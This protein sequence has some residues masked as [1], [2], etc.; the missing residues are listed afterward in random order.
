M[1]F[2][3]SL[4]PV[5]V[6]SIL[7]VLFAIERVSVN[8]R[9]KND[10]AESSKSSVLYAI[11]A[12]SYILCILFSYTEFVF[13]SQQFKLANVLVGL[14][15]LIAGVLLRNAS[16]KELGDVWSFHLEPKSTRIIRSGPYSYFSHPYYLA[17][18]LELAGFSMIFNSSVAAVMIIT[19]QI[20]V[21]FIRIKFESDFLRAC[22]SAA[23]R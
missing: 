17:V 15:A 6:G 2:S 19:I 3:A 21:L 16:I 22:G 10:R 4:N 23:L 9:F 18:C 14:P 7:L 1:M 5:I 8:I 12:A 13:S 20:P 11:A